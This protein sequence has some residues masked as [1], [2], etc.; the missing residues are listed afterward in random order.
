MNCDRMR[1]SDIAAEA[2]LA[3]LRSANGDRSVQDL[4]LSGGGAIA[5]LEEKLARHYGMANALCVS[6]ATAGLHALALALRVERSEFVT[7]PLTY[8][9][10]LAGW[11]H[12][13]GRPV[14]ADID[15][16]TLNID[17]DTIV[18]AIGPKTKALVAVDLHGVPSETSMLRDV[19]RRHG[20]FYVA[21][22]AQ[23]FGATIDGV[24]ASA[25]ADALVVS[26]TAGKT[27]F[28][29]EGGAILTNDTRLHQ[30][31]T[32]LTQHPNRQRRDVGLNAAS[33]FNLNYRMNPLAAAWASAAFEEALA[34]AASHRST[35]RS[36]MATL[37]TTRILDPASTPMRR[38]IE[39][40]YFRHIV[41]VQPDVPDEVVIR[42]QGDMPNRV[43]VVRRTSPV[44]VPDDP[45]FRPWKRRSRLA[46]DLQHV[47]RVLAHVAYVEVAQSSDSATQRG[48]A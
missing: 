18:R 48:A 44:L 31:L 41:R 30:R 22:A 17:P 39:P 36:A 46:V 27:L 8:G 16:A 6:S 5:M 19:A 32:S 33:P 13:G 15:P 29:G 12:A 21:D 43:V 14:F 42:H 4:H 26:F 35:C 37:E 3:F 28:A 1:T 10:T 40:S 9:A 2:V 23:S 25:H 45:A 47:R 34:S 20:L 24:P 11:L 38:G 7:T